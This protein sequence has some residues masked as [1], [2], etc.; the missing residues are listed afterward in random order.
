MVGLVLQPRHAHPLFQEHVLWQ[1]QAKFVLSILN[2][3]FSGCTLSGGLKGVN[4]GE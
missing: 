3:F 2:V 4:V 1:D